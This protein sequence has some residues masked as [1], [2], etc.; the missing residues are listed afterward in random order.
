MGMEE[1]L[2]ET[3]GPGKL[4]AALEQVKKSNLTMSCR[5]H[6]TARGTSIGCVAKPDWRAL[7][8]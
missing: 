2:I 3:S 5:L 1:K 4:Y 8:T 7:D 6:F